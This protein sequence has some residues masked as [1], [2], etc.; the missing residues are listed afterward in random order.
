MELFLTAARELFR[1]GG[2]WDPL[3]GGES[4]AAVCD[5]LLRRDDIPDT[6][7]VDQ[8][9]SVQHNTGAWLNKVS[10]VERDLF[11]AMEV[12]GGDLVS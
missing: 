3:F 2:R 7:W 10:P 5:H 12:F 6:A 11:A 9:F 1:N 4:W 8:S